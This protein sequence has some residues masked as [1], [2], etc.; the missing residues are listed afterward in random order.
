MT[1]PAVLADIRRR[2]DAAA[3]AA[4]RDPGA[5]ALTAVCKQQP[6]EAIA[7]VLAAGQT[8]FGES[9]VQ[10][11]AARWADRRAG[12]E[13]RLIGPLQTNKA[14][15]ATA[16]FDAIETLDRPRLAGVLAGEIQR[17]GC[18]P[19]LFIEVNTGEEPGKSGVAPREADAFV[20]RCRWEYGLAIDGLMCVPP[21]AEPAGPHFALLAK[22]AARN[23]LA[24][25]SMGMSADFET[26]IAFGATHVRL[27]SALFGARP[28]HS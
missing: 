10:E 21:L 27:G 22:I 16:L 1:G 9:R 18:A 26:A 5:V 14:R 23:G 11:A 6:W 25:L 4:G 17:L 8:A 28:P 2:I 15:E 12:V 13:L 19:R 20:A 24:G 3:R 7:P